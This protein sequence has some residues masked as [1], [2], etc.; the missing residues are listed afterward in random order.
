MIGARTGIVEN[1]TAVK[2]RQSIFNL[3]KRFQEK[4]PLPVPAHCEYQTLLDPEVSD[5]SRVLQRS[6]MIQKLRL[7][8]RTG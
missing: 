4:E 3:S 5:V 6:V 7:A 8:M 1:P 2:A